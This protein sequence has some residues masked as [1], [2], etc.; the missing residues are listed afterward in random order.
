MQFTEK[1]HTFVLCA[2]LDNPYLEACIKS[3]LSQSVLGN[4]FITTSTPNDSIK[5]LSERYG[6]PLYINSK[7]TGQ[8]DDLNFGYAMAKTPLVT[9][10]HQDDIYAP[11]FLKETLSSIAP[12]QS[13]IM[14]FT[15]YE[16]ERSGKL[17]HDNRV[18]RIKRGMLLPLRI[19]PLQ[20]SKLIRRCIL[21]IGDPICFPSVTLNKSVLPDVPFRT[22]YSRCPDWEAWER[23]ST[24]KGDFVYCPKRLVFHRIWPGSTTSQCAKDG[25]RFREE[26]EIFERFWPRS[27]AKVLSKLYSTALDADSAD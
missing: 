17:T 15:D 1:D 20:R 7:H 19:R 4:V 22:S 3:I 16:E 5:L 6:L 10:C 27:A 26:Q 8:P 9:L 14:I 13:P 11:D 12:G 25:S 24:L 2:Y 21:A 23:F 18:M